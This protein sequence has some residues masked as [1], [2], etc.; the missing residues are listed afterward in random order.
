MSAFVVSQA[1]TAAE[2]AAGV[3]LTAPD[4]LAGISSA[5]T[6]ANIARWHVIAGLGWSVLYNILALLFAGGAF[7]NVRVPP[8]WAGRGE[9]VSVL[10]VM[11]MALATNWSWRLLRRSSVRS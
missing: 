6:L 3:V 8:Q 4:L 10:P 5:L 9:L 2:A 1:T 7:V 11:V